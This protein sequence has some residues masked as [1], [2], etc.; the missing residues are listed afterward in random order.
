MCVMRSLTTDHSYLVSN[1]HWYSQ[2]S[3]ENPDD[4]DDH[5]G[6]GLGDVRPQGEHDGLIPSVE[7]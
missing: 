4:E 5:L 7:T 2:Y 3:A 1:A 6:P